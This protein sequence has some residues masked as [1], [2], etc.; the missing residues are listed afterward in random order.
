[1]DGL[2]LLHRV[3]VAHP[4]PCCAFAAQGL[5]LILAVPRPGAAAANLQPP[6]VQRRALELAFPPAS[7][8]RPLDLASARSCPVLTSALLLPG[9][10]LC[11]RPLLSRSTMW[12]RKN[13]KQILSW[14]VG[15]LSP[16]QI[17]GAGLVVFNASYCV[18]MLALQHPLRDWCP[19][20][21]S[22]LRGADSERD[23]V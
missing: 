22:P 15:K 20:L 7:R 14:N 10:I 17:A 12:R 8:Q 11:C 5:V 9:T 13:R 18:V 2:F 3:V 16:A 6:K 19:P 1:M 23:R 4:L 21:S